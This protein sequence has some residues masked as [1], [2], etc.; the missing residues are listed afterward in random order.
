MALAARNRCSIIVEAGAAGE[1]D[2]EEASVTAVLMG[3]IFGEG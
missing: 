3:E 2:P 1:A